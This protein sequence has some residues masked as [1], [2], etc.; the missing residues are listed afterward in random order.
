MSKIDDLEFDLEILR[1]VVYQIEDDMKGLAAELARVKELLQ[2][3][4]RAA[5][6]V[7]VESKSGQH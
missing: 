5:E 2:D 7:R 3:A 6:D 4:K 1:D